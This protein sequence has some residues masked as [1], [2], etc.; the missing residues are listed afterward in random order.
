MEILQTNYLNTSTMLTVP[1]NTAAASRLFDKRPDRQYKT[2]GYTGST[3]GVITIDLVQTATV[4]RIIL[5]NHNLKDFTIFYNGATANTLTLTSTCATTTTDW[6]TNSETS[7]YLSFSP[8]A[9]TSLSIQMSATMANGDERAIGQIII[10]D[11]LYRFTRNPDSGGYRPNVSAR[12]ISHTMSDGGSVT[13]FIRNKVNSKLTL[14]HYDDWSA[15]KDVYDDN[16]TVL[17]SPFPTGTAWDGDIF[18]CNWTGG[19]KPLAYT[20]NIYNNG[21]DV[22]IDLK[23]T[24]S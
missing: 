6:A 1:A 12:E 10:A 22:D 13:Y 3:V 16:K 5:L 14:K 19:F 2:V 4:S 9:M 7:I 21:R 8:V 11:Q 24:A 17:F 20:T 15:L 23:E 18:E